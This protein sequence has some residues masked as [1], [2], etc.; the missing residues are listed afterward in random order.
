MLCSAP[1]NVMAICV[2]SRM[3]L[4]LPVYH[5]AVHAFRRLG[6]ARERLQEAT[7]DYAF[8]PEGK[9]DEVTGVR[10]LTRVR[11]LQFKVRDW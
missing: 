5:M 7:G 2:S 9:L 4:C 10:K 3:C 6:K 1:G 11:D 8:S